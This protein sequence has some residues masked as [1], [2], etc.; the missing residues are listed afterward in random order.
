MRTKV[1]SGRKWIS[2][3]SP[4][5]MT[6]SPISGSITDSSAE[7]AAV[8]GAD[9]I[10]RIVLAVDVEYRYGL[11]VDPHQLDTPFGNLAHAGHGDEAVGRGAHGRH[12]MARARQP[13]PTSYPTLTGCSPPLR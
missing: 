2:R 10:D 5:S 8:V 4:R 3:I 6:E 1:L 13:R 11:I 9:V 12:P 7:R